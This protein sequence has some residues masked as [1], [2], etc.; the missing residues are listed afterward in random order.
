[1]FR[2]QLFYFPIFFYCHK[3]NWLFEQSAWICKDWI[4][5]SRGDRTNIHFTVTR[6]SGYLRWWRQ[7][8]AR[9]WGEVGGK[10]QHS[11]GNKEK[12]TQTRWG[13]HF[14]GAGVWFQPDTGRL[15]GCF[16]LS[17]LTHLSRWNKNGLLYRSLWFLL[18]FFV[19]AIFVLLCF[20][21]VTRNQLSPPK[22]RTVLHA[23]V[24][25]T[26]C[27]PADII[28][29]MLKYIKI[30]WRNRIN[31]KITWIFYKSLQKNFSFHRNKAGLLW[32][33]VLM[34]KQAKLK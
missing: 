2:L 13:L 3:V 24:S 4:I 15:L 6:E 1:M 21:V 17:C 29:F 5:F 34:L 9:G 28:F 22:F 11:E 23:T 31:K 10:S 19:F 7:G 16:Y 33:Y 18:W 30:D 26:T 20:G 32:V 14:H 8:C 25:F 27:N 12:Q